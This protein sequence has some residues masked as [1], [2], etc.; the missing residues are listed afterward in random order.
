MP[1]KFFFVILVLFAAIYFYS[2]SCNCGNEN[3]IQI[4]DN[5]I[6]KA[7][8]FLISNYG[9]DFF[10]KYIS[11]DMVRTQYD[12]PYFNM[13]YDFQIPNKSYNDELI[14]FSVDSLGKIADDREVTGVC[15]CQE[16][17]EYCR[18]N[19]D[20]TQVKNIASRKGLEEGIKEWKV[21]LLWNEKYQRYLWHVL[22]TLQETGDSIN[23]RGN[24]KEVVIEPD[25]GKVLE[26]N[27]WNLK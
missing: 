1:G 5:V 16:H 9:K 2:C 7:N 24:G 20:K 21:G 3:M 17:S 12:H 25:S 6:N 19:I 27:E 13:V 10:E 15:N 14:K 26:F 11:L 22:N 18:F 23:Y 4:P 8:E